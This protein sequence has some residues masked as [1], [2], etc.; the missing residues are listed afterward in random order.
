[1]LEPRNEEEAQAFEM[2]EHFF[3]NDYIDRGMMKWQGFYLSDQIEN[4][5]KV[6]RE[7]EQAMQ[8]EQMPNMREE[9]ISA[10]LF[11]AYRN[12]KSVE[13]QLKGM[14]VDSLYPQIVSGAVKGYAEENVYIGNTSIPL[15]QINWCQIK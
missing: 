11:N 15:G 13:Y 6:K 12:H 10:V 14:T 7:R 4:V 2:A 1:M 5:E 3:R 8:Q 9:E